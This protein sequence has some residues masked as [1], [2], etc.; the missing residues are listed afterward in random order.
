MTALIFLAPLSGFNERLPEDNRINRLEDSFALWRTICTNKLL[1][2]VQLVSNCTRYQ[3]LLLTNVEQ[4][5]FMNKTDILRKKIEQDK[6][7]IRTYIPDY[8]KPNDFE[9]VANCISLSILLRA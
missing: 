3:S 1:E 5:L 4:I 9:S 2:N 8:D 7:Q 6:I